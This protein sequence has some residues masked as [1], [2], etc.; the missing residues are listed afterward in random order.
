VTAVVDF[1]QENGAL[2]FFL[3]VVLFVVAWTIVSHFVQR[4]DRQ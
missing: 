4:G 3:F 2:A 1:I